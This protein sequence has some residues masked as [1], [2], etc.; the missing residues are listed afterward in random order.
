MSDFLRKHWAPITDAAW[1]QIEAQA[2]R[3]LKGHLSA[4]HFISVIGPMG[5]DFSA[6]NT[7]RVRATEAEPVPGVRWGV[8]EVK[9]L[10]ESRAAFELLIWELD[11]ADRG[12]KDLDLSALTR[13]AAAIALFEEQTIWN[14]HREAGIEGI[15]GVSP[16]APIAVKNEPAALVAAL[17]R[18]LIALEK[19][20]IG[21]PFGLATDA[22]IYEQLMSGAPGGYPIRARVEAFF[23]AG[24]R[25]SPAIQGAAILSAR[26]GDYELTLGQD[27]SIGYQRHDPRAVTLYFTESF[28][29]RVIEPAAAVAVKIEG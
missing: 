21:G 5:W 13:A 7:G 20:G 6:V 15:L 4:R 28:A 22:V 24:I 1:T 26:G 19:A 12:A 17:E 2:T 3:A 10:I 25:W 18:G 14:G 27:L 11:N 29:F 9:P 23:K 8:R 16:H